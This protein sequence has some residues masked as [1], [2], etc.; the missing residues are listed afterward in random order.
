MLSRLYSS[1]G[2]RRCTPNILDFKGPES[3][4]LLKFPTG[5]SNLTISFSSLPAHHLAVKLADGKVVWCKLKPVVNHQD[6]DVQTKLEKGWCILCDLAPIEGDLFWKKCSTWTSHWSPAP[7]RRNGDS[8]R[9]NTKGALIVLL[10]SLISWRSRGWSWSWWRTAQP[11]SDVWHSDSILWLLNS[12]SVELRYR[13]SIFTAVSSWSTSSDDLPE[14]ILVASN[15]IV[16][17]RIEIMPKTNT[18]SKISARP[19]TFISRR[20]ESCVDAM[21]FS[22]SQALISETC[23]FTQPVGSDGHSQVLGAVHLLRNTNLGSR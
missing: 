1:L 9:R 11:T 17:V 21:S 20:R 13:D 3:S 7:C 2:P 12:C 6:R 18:G 19:P 23:P 10:K 8:N 14:N 15:S 4:N 16:W 22:F 5:F